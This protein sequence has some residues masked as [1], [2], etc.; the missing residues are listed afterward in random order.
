MNTNQNARVIS[1]VKLLN[2]AAKFKEISFFRVL[3][4]S[5]FIYIFVFWRHGDM[6]PYRDGQAV[7]SSGAVVP[8]VAGTCAPAAPLTWPHLAPGTVCVCVCQALPGFQ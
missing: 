6:R 4:I 8:C 5:I 2:S 3:G 7:T 1:H